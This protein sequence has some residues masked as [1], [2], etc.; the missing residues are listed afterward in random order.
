MSDRTAPSVRRAKGSVR[1][2]RPLHVVQTPLYDR[3]DPL[4]IV[5]R[6]AFDRSYPSARLTMGS[7]PRL[8][9]L[10]LVQRGLFDRTDP[11]VTHAAASGNRTYPSVKRAEGSGKPDKECTDNELRR[12]SAPGSRRVFVEITTNIPAADFNHYKQGH[13]IDSS[14]NRL[15]I[16]R[17]NAS[18][19]DLAGKSTLNAFE[20]WMLR[21]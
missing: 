11:S 9:P 16:V 19:N 6:G 5:Q 15:L 1:R 14:K 13:E 18:I 21:F 10:Q 4:H 8:R 3:T 12:I 2:Q 17:R 7:V 20:A